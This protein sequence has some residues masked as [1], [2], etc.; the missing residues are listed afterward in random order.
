MI[1]RT[2]STL[3]SFKQ[4]TFSPGLNIILADRSTDSTDRQTRNS[5]GKTSLIELIHFSTGATCAPDSIFRNEALIEHS[6]GVDMDI[7]G[8]PITV[9]RSGAHASK[10][11]VEGDTSTWPIRPRTDKKT[12]Q[13]FI[14]N[15]N[16]KTLLGSMFFGLP[17]GEEEK[18]KYLPTFRSLF[19]YFVRRHSAGA[20]P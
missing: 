20:L 12:G 14:T 11:E 19:A 17:E 2:F 10:L 1:H 4:M 15:T 3:P 5:A 18:Q 13:V 16:W 6:F 8:K 9:Q 7:K